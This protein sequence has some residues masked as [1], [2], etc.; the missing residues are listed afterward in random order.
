MARVEAARGQFG[1]NTF[2]VKSRGGD[3][4]YAKY[5]TDDAGDYIID[6][7][8]QY[9]YIVPADYDMAASIQRYVDAAE[10]AKSTP[11]PDFSDTSDRVSEYSLLYSTFKQGG[12]G[13]LQRTYNGT[14]SLNPNDFVPDF[15]DAASFNFGM[16]GA[17][18]GLTG[19]E[20]LAGGGLYNYLRSQKPD[21]GNII[22]DGEFYNNPSNVT[23]IGVGISAFF[24]DL[25]HGSAS[26]EDEAKGR[27]L[28]D[29]LLRMG[30][31][32]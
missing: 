14:S 3:A 10:K 7:I 1:D 25:T 11:D 29:M 28:Y 4:V 8:T 19:N 30:E 18:L 26:P 2:T 17:A 24:G 20:V 5:L 16:T 12:D 21:G 32:R 9:P 13:D 27:S 6:P 31:V 23:S 15:T 22:T